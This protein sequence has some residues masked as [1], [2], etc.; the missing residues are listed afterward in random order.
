MV[1]IA[2]AA[3][4]SCGVAPTL[5]E[6]TRFKVICSF[7]TASETRRLGSVQH[8]FCGSW[9]HVGCEHL[10]LIFESGAGAVFPRDQT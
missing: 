9:A 2:R 3:V 5:G 10:R 7:R 4:G 1:A 8:T 6:A